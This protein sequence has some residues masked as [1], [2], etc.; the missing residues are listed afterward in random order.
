MGFFDD[1]PERE[2]RFA[3][4]PRRPPDWSGP[5]DNMVGGAVALDLVL[6]N[7]GDAALAL[8]AAVA[9]PTGVAFTVTGHRRYTGD[10]RFGD[11]FHDLRLGVGLADGRRVLSD[12]WQEEADVRLVERGGGGG[13]LRW[14]WEF[15]LWPLPPEGTLQIACAWPE[16]GID[17]TVVEADAGPIRAAA[18]RAVEL[19]VDERPVGGAAV[20]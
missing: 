6:A 3:V 4:D 14:D 8:P 15:W 11:P 13:G 1:V 2:E 19:W 7:T 9:Y 16:A 17:E 10:R 12:D 5:P 20:W 18:A